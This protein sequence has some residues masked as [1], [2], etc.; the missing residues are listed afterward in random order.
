MILGSFAVGGPTAT[1][2]APRVPD[3]TVGHAV[4]MA[5]DLFNALQSAFEST[6]VSAVIVTAGEDYP[7]T[8]VACIATARFAVV[9]PD[10]ALWGE[11][12]GRREWAITQMIAHVCNE[13]GLFSPQ[14]KVGGYSGVECLPARPGGMR[15]SLGSGVMTW[16]GLN[17]PYHS[18]RG[19]RWLPIRRLPEDWAARCVTAVEETAADSAEEVEESLLYFTGGG[20]RGWE[21]RKM[22]PPP[23]DSAGLNPRE[24]AALVA[25]FL[26]GHASYGALKEHVLEC[27]LSLEDLY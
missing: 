22:C 3:P 4:N 2:T 16:Y 10:I 27:N 25:S 19:M 11:Q 20:E 18:H 21:E 26:V 15:W 9:A 23:A 17:S 7:L 8:R 1:S 13:R 12:G 14:F 24:K 6:C 5:G